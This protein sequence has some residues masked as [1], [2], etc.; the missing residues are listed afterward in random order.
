MLLH[1]T[2]F[3]ATV[4]PLR[5]TMTQQ[6]TLRVEYAPR[7]RLDQQY[8]F[9][10]TEGKQLLRIQ[11]KIDSNPTAL[12]VHW[13]RYERSADGFLARKATLIL[14]NRRFRW[15][16]NGRTLGIT[17]LKRTDDG[18]Y[19]IQVAN[20]RGSVERNITLNVFCEYIYIHTHTYTVPFYIYSVL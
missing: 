1:Y 19:A 20:A 12:V 16:G 17:D 10:A 5:E 13:F 11:I 6:Y 7:L 18:I 9:N 8:V 15:D 14:Q 3:R 4:D 2:I